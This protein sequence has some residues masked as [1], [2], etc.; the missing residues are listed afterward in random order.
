MFNAAGGPYSGFYKTTAAVGEFIFI[1]IT[2]LYAFPCT[3]G[4]I[5]SITNSPSPNNIHANSTSSDR[6]F[7]LP[8]PELSTEQLVD[9]R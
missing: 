4:C 5:V 7:S 6:P 2:A 8:M 3:C 9:I 1:C